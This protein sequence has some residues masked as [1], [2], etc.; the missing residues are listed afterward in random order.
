MTVKEAMILGLITI[1]GSAFMFSYFSGF[2]PSFVI[3]SIIA[4]VVVIGLFSFAA[5]KKGI[6]G[7]PK[8]K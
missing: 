8:K 2:Q 4:C 6:F 7:N 1:I 5:Y 3:G